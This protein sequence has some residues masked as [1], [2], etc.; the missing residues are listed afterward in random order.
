MAEKKVILVILDGWG[1]GENTPANAVK[2]AHTPCFDSLIA[3]Y[4]HSELRTDGLNVGLPEGQMG[5]SE[6]GHL[7]LGAGRVIYQ[8]LVEINLACEDGTLETNEELVK[9]FEYAKANNK[10]VHMMGLVSD[11]CIHSSDK[12]LYKL[13]EIAKKHSLVDVFV[14]AFTDGRDTDPKSGVNFLKNLQDQLLQTT[15]EIASVI[16]RYYAMDRDKRWERV[17]QAYNLLVKGEGLQTTDV[18]GAVEQS[19]I[20]GITDEFIKPIVKVN[21]E[22]SPVA[23][24]KP[25]DVVICFNYRTDRCREITEVLT[26]QDFAEQG[27][28]KLDLYYLTMTPYDHNFKNVKVI[29]NKKDITNTLG[30]VLAN[31]G[32]TQ[33]RIAETEK[34]PHVTFFFSGGR[35]VQFTGESR[36]LVPSPKDVPTYD[37]KPEM[38]A[39]GIAEAVVKDMDEHAPDFICLNYANPDMVGHTGVFPAIVKAV[40]TVD[41]CLQ[42][43]IDKALEK[44]YSAIILADHGNAEFAINDD[45]TPNTAHTTNPVPCILID[46]DHK[47]LKDGKLA[48][49]A[50]TILAL[51]GLI[52]PKEMG[53]DVLI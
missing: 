8:D 14:H 24:I 35:E 28:R 39:F 19:Y 41:Q 42:M 46:N 16:G 26:Q 22:G 21:A 23:T 31:A 18:I 9:A 50:P 11:G 33:L 43:T 25:G 29:F 51:M 37:F 7:N 40:E 12:H 34:Y 15:G 5:N 49:I 52:A 17:A 1:I 27:M 36:I 6:V 20:E 38:S 44:G 13:C 45:G 4:P 32:K 3:K 48:D 10:A 30:E 2:A 47:T 53:G